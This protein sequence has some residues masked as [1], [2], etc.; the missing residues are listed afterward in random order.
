MI[1]PLNIPQLSSAKPR[2][3]LQ[4]VSELLP[5]LIQMY[6]LQ[7]QARRQIEADNQRHASI[8]GHSGEQSTFDWY[9]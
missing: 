6:E 2:G 7:A 3:G 8:N 4:S 5:R 9:Q 1:Q